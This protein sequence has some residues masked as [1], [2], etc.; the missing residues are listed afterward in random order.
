VSGGWNN[1]CSTQWVNR[2]SRVPLLPRLIY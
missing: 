2:V 1:I